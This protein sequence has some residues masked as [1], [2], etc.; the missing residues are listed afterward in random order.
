[1]TVP[2]SD[3][4]RAP[5]GK[6]VDLNGV[7]TWYQDRGK[8]ETVVLLHGGFTDSRDFDGN[9]DG[10]TS[11][12]RC[13]FPERRGHGHTP[14]VEGPI[15]GEIMA[16]VTENPP[17]VYVFRN[18]EWGT[19]GASITEAVG[20]SLKSSPTEIT[21]ALDARDLPTVAWTV[22]PITG[23]DA[24]LDEEASERILIARWNSGPWE[25]IGAGSAR[26]P[27]ICDP[28]L[29][30]CM[31]PALA[32]D[33]QGNAAVAFQAFVNG[34]YQVWLRTAGPGL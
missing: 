5:M 17:Q 30:H 28:L 26:P 19:L 16:A 8:G 21:L 4:T 31:S 9:L 34:T 18:G 10:L 27:G 15:S 24:H 6:R 29:G 2:A 25:E 32:L 1:M 22:S 12:F 7:N 13:L 11:R 3:E 14:D 23:E 33:A 20:S